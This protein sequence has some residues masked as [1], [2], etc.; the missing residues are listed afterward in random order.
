MH[1]STKQ[2][3]NRGEVPLH[4]IEIIEKKIALSKYH[5]IHK[6]IEK[7]FASSKYLHGLKCNQGLFLLLKNPSISE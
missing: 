2:P 5:K 6:I 3:T 1:C 4:K 7:R